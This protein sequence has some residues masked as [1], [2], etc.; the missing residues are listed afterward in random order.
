MTIDEVKNYFGSCY[1]Y[2]KLTGMSASNFGNWVVK[3]YIPIKA[4]I[5]IEQFS[6]GKLRA[7]IPRYG[8]S[9]EN[10]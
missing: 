3:G 1:N 4:Q 10:E 6:K 8:E 7:S 2:R 9:D 5:Q